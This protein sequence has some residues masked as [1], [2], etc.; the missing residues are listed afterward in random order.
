MNDLVRYDAMCRAIDAAHAVDE[1]KEIRDKA[2]AMEAYFRVAKNPEPER[3]ACEIRIRAERRAGQILATMDRAKRGNSQ[4]SRAPTLKDLG[5]SRDQSST[6]QQLARVPNDEFEAA[7]GG[8]A[9]PSTT[10]MVNGANAERRD[11]MDP[12]ALWLWGR[13]RDLEREGF[14]DLVP[15]SLLGEMTD[16]MR[17]DVMRI[18]PLAMDWLKG[19]EHEQ[20]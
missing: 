7:L 3:R 4:T 16:A 6:W 1:V 20:G 5:V 10:R 9:K 14:F 17:D 12:Q 19:F 18:I 11:P 15:M 8:E 2:V 13:L